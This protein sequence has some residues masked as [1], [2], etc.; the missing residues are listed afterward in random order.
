MGKFCI[1]MAKSKNHTSH[2]QGRKNHRNG[3]KKPQRERYSSNLMVNAKKMRNDKRSKK[4]DPS[5]VKQKNL[6]KKIQKLRE[7]K[8]TIVS[9]VRQVRINKLLGIK[10]PKKGQAQEDPKKKVDAKKKG[11]K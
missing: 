7:L 10:K 11:K 6:T 1:K 5:I 9:R 3:I 8:S 4:F 2:H